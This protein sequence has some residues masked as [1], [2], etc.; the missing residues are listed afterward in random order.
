MRKILI[1]VV[2]VLNVSLNIE[3]STICLDFGTE[4]IAQACNNT[5]GMAGYGQYNPNNSSSGTGSTP[6]WWNAI[7]NWFSTFFGNVGQLFNGQNTSPGQPY[8]SYPGFGGSIYPPG[9]FN[10]DQTNGLGGGESQQTPNYTYD[11][12]GTL[13][14]TAGLDSCGTCANGNTGIVPCNTPK[15]YVTVNNSNTKFYNNDTIK[16]FASDTLL[17]ITLHNDVLGGLPQ[18]LNWYPCNASLN[19][20]F[21]WP[22]DLGK[23]IFVN[24]S[25]VGFCPISISQGS[26][27]A[28]TTIHSNVINVL[29]PPQP[30]SIKLNN[31]PK[32]Y[33]DG[34]E[35]YITSQ[36]N[37]IDSLSVNF[38]N[39]T[40]P[41]NELHWLKDSVQSCVGNALCAF[42]FS[43]SGIYTIR[44]N[45]AQGNKQ[46]QVKVIVCNKS[47]IKF[48]NKLNYSGEYGFDEVGYQYDSLKNDYQKF[49]ICNFNY[50][51]PWMSLLHGQTDTIACETIVSQ[52]DLSN[53]SFWVEIKSSNSDSIKINNLPANT[54]F[55]L[56]GN[57]LANL[58]TLKITG[59]Q[60]SAISNHSK[61]FIFAVNNSG[62]TIGK[63]H[64]SC[65]RPIRKKLVI[66]YTNTGTGYRD[67]LASGKITKTEILNG[68]N[69]KS[70][71]QIF[72]KWDLDTTLPDKLDITTEYYL[73]SM[74]NN[75]TGIQNSSLVPSNLL[76]LYKNH[77]GFDYVLLNNGKNRDDSTR[78]Y[79]LF[80]TDLP[81][82]SNF[83]GVVSGIGREAACIMRKSDLSTVIHELGHN[84]KLVHTFELNAETWHTNPLFKQYSPKI[85]KYSTKNYMDYGNEEER[86]FYYQWLKSN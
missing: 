22:Y 11:C 24:V 76:N 33:Y 54:A 85:T 6:G 55:H 18:P 66:I 78:Y 32:K 26:I 37:N 8:N 38:P 79:F 39:N 17:P 23:T 21:W 34:D 46:I 62:D 31:N 40:P 73:D 35:I 28:Q 27:I 65:Q 5:N 9:F 29:P 51:V 41:T 42:N 86:F 30:K 48:H 58:S 14:G 56:N 49:S 16:V 67:T 19:G 7:T 47:I 12:S 64:I 83:G 15:Y 71:N 36:P 20:F 25:E 52:A 61:A 82:K 1:I 63:L 69:K 3:Q 59:Y 53:S 10:Q 75:F 72:K 60:F 50:K 84:L 4:A 74:N 70:H 77:T 80:I 2:L 43:T 81:V 68:L 44:V 57:Q 45:D 13:N